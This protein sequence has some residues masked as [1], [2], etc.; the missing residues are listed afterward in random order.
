MHCNNESIFQIIR[1]IPFQIWHLYPPDPSITFYGYANVSRIDSPRF[2]SL[3]HWRDAHIN[4]EFSKVDDD[5]LITN[6]G[7]YRAS[8]HAN[9]PT[10]SVSS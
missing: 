1:Q 3:L 6:S 7:A 4:M 9:S 8:L 5:S 10:R 2:N